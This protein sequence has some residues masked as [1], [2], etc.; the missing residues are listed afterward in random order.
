MSVSKP[1]FSTRRPT[2]IMRKGA[3]TARRGRSGAV[4]ENG[5]GQDRDRPDQH[6]LVCRL[7]TVNVLP[8]NGCMLRQ[9]P[10]HG[11]LLII[12]RAIPIRVRSRCLLHGRKRTKARRARSPHIV[13]RRMGCA[14]SE[15]R[16]PQGCPQP[17]APERRPGPNGGGGWQCHRGQDHARRPRRQHQIQAGGN[18]AHSV[19][20]TARFFVQVFGQITHP[21]L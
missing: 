8:Q 7:A 2:D 19:M 20:H 13:R 6:G 17:H 12:S 15:H 21:R 16:A 1:F 14:G 10:R 3:S 5:Q 11:W 9:R 18:G 4:Q